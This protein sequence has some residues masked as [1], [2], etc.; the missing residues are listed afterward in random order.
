MTRPLLSVVI[1]T[2]NRARLVPEA[3]E[4][5]LAQGPGR[6][7][8]VV[9]DDASD[10]GTAEQLESRFGKAIKLVRRPE[11]GGAGAARN[12]GVAVAGGHL[13]AFLDS[14]DL[15]LP[16][17]LDAE[18]ALLERFPEAEAVVSDS[19]VFQEGRPSPRTWFE[20][21]GLLA[22]AG[23]RAGWLGDC[24]WLWTNWQNTLAICSITLRRA[25]LARLGQ[26]AFSEDLNSC[27]D[28]ELELR[29]Y[30]GGRVLVLPEV[31]AH[32][33]RFE[34][35]TRSGRRLPGQ[36]ATRRVLRDRLSVLERA[37]GL[38]G[39]APELFRE[40]ER[41]LAVTAQQLASSEEA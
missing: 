39:L 13:L 5:A 1:P 18:L 6:V 29:L 14:D 22:A 41:G 23:G 32:V 11:R 10:D 30:S 7:E 21:N 28:W 36:P 16:G 26:P 38:R 9:V 8:V 35:G 24:P 33:R 17:K 34:D 19:L 40:L 37:R 2:W 31:W 27:E 25:A 3:V 12:D 4:S 20:S 15:W